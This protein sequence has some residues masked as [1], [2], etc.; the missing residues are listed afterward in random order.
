MGAQTD[1]ASPENLKITAPG[2]SHYKF[3]KDVL[4]RADYTSPEFCLDVSSRAD[5]TSPEFYEDVHSRT[6]YT[7][8]EFCE[9]V[10][11]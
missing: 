11:S 9:N 3:C 4:S 5:Y 8:P 2:P 1:Y 6:D 7:S 10:H